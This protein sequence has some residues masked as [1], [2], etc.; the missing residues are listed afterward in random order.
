[1]AN[2]WRLVNRVIRGADILL[3]VLDARMIEES[4]NIEIEDKV[5]KSGKQL[6]YVIN[7]C[8]LADKKELEQIKKTLRPSVFVSAKE[9]LGTSYLRAEILKNAPAGEFVV[10][11][12]GYPNTGK[13]SLINVLLGRSVA[14]TSP[15]SGYTHGLQTVRI[16]QRMLVIDTPGVLPYKEQDEAKHAMIAA[17]TAGNLKDPEESAMKIIERFPEIIEKYY[18]IKHGD[19]SEET[20]GRIAIKMKRLRKGGLPDTNSAARMMLKDWQEGKM[21][22]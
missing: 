14:K 6:I 20:L 7:K 3:E 22:K 17:K 4:R 15:V 10:G 5:K 19:D 11:V 9:H 18:G 1:M 13:S 8:D 16:S 2:Y 21:A 12:L